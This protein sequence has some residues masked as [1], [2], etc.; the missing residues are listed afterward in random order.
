M[1]TNIVATLEVV[2][3]PTEVHA[4]LTAISSAGNSFKPDTLKKI[5]DFENHLRQF[6][7]MITAQLVQDL[8]NNYNNT[9]SVSKEK[10]KN[11]S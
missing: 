3:T 2:L 6:D 1:R 10:D 4:V 11:A 7:D 5:I 8:D 9:A